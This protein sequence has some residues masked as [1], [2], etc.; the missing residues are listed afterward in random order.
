ML[1]T[2]AA[3]QDLLVLQVCFVCRDCQDPSSEETQCCCEAC[4]EQ[5][6]AGH[7][8]VH[9]GYGRCFCDC[10]ASGHCSEAH[11]AAALAAATRVLGDGR[12][13][14]A[15]ATAA[16]DDAGGDAV[17]ARALDVVG[18]DPCRTA[19]LRAECVRIASASKETFWMRPEAA[20]RNAME[21]L[22]ALTF[23]HHTAG[24]AP[25]SFDRASSGAEFWTQVKDPASDAAGVDLHYDKDEALAEAFGLGVFPRVSTVTYLE[26]AVAAAAPPRPLAPT[27]VFSAR[28]T[29][30]VGSD[31]ARAVVSHPA[32]AKQLA[33]DGS[34]LHGAP[35]HAALRR[36][37]TRGDNAPTCHEARL[38]AAAPRITFLVNIWLDHRPCGIIELS[39]AEVAATRIPTGNAAGVAPAETVE[40]QRARAL[41][42]A[43]AVRL[44]PQDV[45]A[46]DLLVGGDAACRERSARAQRIALPFVSRSATWGKGEGE[47][48]LVLSM[49]V[50]A[51]LAEAEA[52]TLAL[53]FA[54]DVGPAFLEPESDSDEEEDEIGGEEEE[55]AEAVEVAEAEEEEEAGEEVEAEGAAEEKPE[56]EEE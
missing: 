41:A 2:Y 9:L 21:A 17:F 31:I 29:E 53:R 28:I 55:E 30:S 8:V 3:T 34:L 7:D 54:D 13:L 25:G 6:H 43:D 5:C 40:V 56:V 11:A 37:G 49:P 36:S 10:A 47:G 35:A 44:A 4:A 14:S 38:A 19:A 15:V 50:S 20:P 1:C 51:A 45:A 27:I 23:S 26:T 42:F 46:S 52:D 48:G 39:D 33:F 32:P 16:R 24:L 12:A 18:L 22:A